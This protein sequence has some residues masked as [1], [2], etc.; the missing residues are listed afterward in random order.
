MYFPIIFL[1]PILQV[2]VLFSA[3]T[4]FQLQHDIP[5]SLLKDST[6]RKFLDIFKTYQLQ[7]NAETVFSD[8]DF[9]NRRFA[10]GVYACPQAI[11]NHMHE[12]LN[13]YLAAVATNR[14]ILWK[15]CNRKPCQL[16]IESDCNLVLERLPWIPS[17][18]Q[19]QQVWKDK[20]CS[21]SSD[22]FNFVSQGERHRADEIFM[23][24]GID[25]MNKYALLNYGTH[26]M[27]QFMGLQHKN[28]LLLNSTKEVVKTLFEYGEDFLYGILFRTTFKFQPSIIDKNN[29]VLR[30]HNLTSLLS[31]QQ[32]HHSLHHHAVAA[33]HH[34][35][36]VIGVHLR[37][38]GNSEDKEH[39]VDQQGIACVNRLLERGNHTREM[40]HQRP[41]II[42]LA[43]DRN[44]SLNYW[45]ASPDVY[46]KIII[47]DHTE[48]H[49]EWTEHGPFTG[50]IA[51]RD[52]E[53]VSRA[54]YFIGSQYNT[55][56]LMNFGSTFS[57]LMAERRASSG[58][59]HSLRT[60][61]H[62]LLDCVETIGNRFKPK[63]MYI[64]ENFQCDRGE[65]PD[66]CPN[67]QR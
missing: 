48:S 44:Q 65:I 34:V 52:F 49:I 39:T 61:A 8:P 17:L 55:P 6:Y 7:H 28:A 3:G 26:E 40:H 53:L 1:F 63:D 22:E 66:A 13:N 47:T 51:M 2:L 21:E 18:S 29:A 20:N 11:G 43:S 23:C 50:E 64:N 9:C 30:A 45:K 57:L 56:A 60:K 67:S 31:I 62:W 19:F 5:N 38:S 36:T 27:H 16:D 24:C 4:G 54:D 42:L 35:P 12:F 10:V 58:N 59:R 37:H 46:C 15:F 32:Q 14:T 41:C 25:Q 33:K